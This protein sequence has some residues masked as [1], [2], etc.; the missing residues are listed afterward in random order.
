MVKEDPQLMEDASEKIV[1]VRHEQDPSNVTISGSLE[2]ILID[3]SCKSVK[4]LALM[5]KAE[6]E[7][8]WTI[9]PFDVDG[10]NFHVSFTTEDL[11]AEYVFKLQVN[12][13]LEDWRESSQQISI[14]ALEEVGLLP[15]KLENYH[16]SFID[17]YSSWSALLENQVV[18]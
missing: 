6:A 14:K 12:G 2:E 8:E 11:C 13:F 18:Q 16:F 10:D 4:E 3:R 17:I 15:E 7:V 9:V 1:V 5:Y